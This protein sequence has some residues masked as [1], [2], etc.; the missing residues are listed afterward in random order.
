RLDRLEDAVAHGQSVVEDGDAGGLGVLQPAVEPDLHSGIPS[1]T[2]YVPDATASSRDAFSSVS[3]HSRS[4]SDPQVIPAP[5]PNRSTAPPSASRS[6][7]KVRMPTASSPVPRSASTHPMPPQYG[8][9]GAGS[10]SPMIRMA[11]DLGAPVTEPGGKAAS[12]SSGQPA[13]ARSSPRTVD[14]RC[15][16]PGCFSTAHRSGTVTV[17]VA[18]TRDRKSTRLNSSHVKI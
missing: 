15:T 18:Q 14:T 17:P 16:R 11:L 12:S 6:I 13:P 7:Q 2:S 10:R 3:R 8:P 1:L 5:V 4:G 9:R